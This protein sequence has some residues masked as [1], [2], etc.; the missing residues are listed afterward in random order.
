MYVGLH[1]HDLPLV[2]CCFRCWCCVL[3]LLFDNRIA[4]DSSVRAT[5]VPIPNTVVKPDSANGTPVARPRE[6]R[7][8]PA[9]HSKRSVALTCDGPFCLVCTHRTISSSSGETTFA[10]STRIA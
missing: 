6:S 7:P 4:G 2:F 9:P 5:P 8:L 1:V 10:T 3:V